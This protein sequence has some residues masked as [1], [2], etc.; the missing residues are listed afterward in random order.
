MFVGIDVF[1]RQSNVRL[2]QLCR[3]TMLSDSARL[4]I[5]VLIVS[6]GG[7]LIVQFRGYRT[8]GFRAAVSGWRALYGFRFF[9][10]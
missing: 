7:R 8:E 10:F 3:D 2:C 6:Y 5:K 9:K 4:K 1:G